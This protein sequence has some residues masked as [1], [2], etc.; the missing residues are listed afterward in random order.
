MSFKIHWRLVIKGAV[1]ALGVI[2][3]FDVLVNGG[4][5]VG[6]VSEGGAVDQFGFEGAPEGLHGGVVVAV[7]AGAHAGGD[8]PGL[9]QGEEAA[10]GILFPLIGMVDESG[11]GLAAGQGV[12]EGVPDEE[13]MEGVDRKSVV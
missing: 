8:L 3:V 7:A 1:E 11:A 2:K 5:G 13:A 10:A 4:A 9:E 6:Q 12:L